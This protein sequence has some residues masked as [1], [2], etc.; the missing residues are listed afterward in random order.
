MKH[1]YTLESITIIFFVVI[2]IGCTTN[3]YMHQL[4]IIDALLIDEQSTDAEKLL[5][6]IDT[7]QLNKEELAFYELLT[8]QKS[9]QLYHPIKKN[10][11]INRCIGYFYQ[12][13]D[14]SKLARAYYYK[15]ELLFYQGKQKESVI[16]YKQ[17]EKIV[18]Q[19]D[20][21]LRHHIYEAVAYANQKD[22]AYALS[23]QYSRA[24]L[25]LSQKLHKPDWEAYAYHMMASNFEG[26][27]RHD[28][29]EIY[30][31][32]VIS[33]LP[34]MTEKG[35]KYILT[36]LGSYYQVKDSK[37][38]DTLMQTA[39]QQPNNGAATLFM[40]GLR[41]NQ[42]RKVEAYDLLNQVE[43][44]EYG[45]NNLSLIQAKRDMKMGDGD[46]R[47]A[48]DLSMQIMALKDSFQQVRARQ[49]L[50]TVQKEFNRRVEQEKIF[51]LISYAIMGI[52]FLSMFI[53]AVVFYYKYRTLH[54]HKLL[55]QD[56]RQ[57]TQLNQQVK[58]A[59]LVP[60]TEEVTQEEKEKRIKMLHHKIINIEERHSGILAIGRL[61]YMDIKEEKTTI[62]WGKMD[63]NAFAE[64][65]KLIDIEFMHHLEE[66]YDSL[67]DKN[68]TLLILESMKLPCERIALI[69]GVSQ[70]AIRTARSRIE[71][72]HKLTPPCE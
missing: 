29:T 48:N 60:D 41:Y 55:D 49:N 58:M 10:S 26:L 32:L 34:K 36:S 23:L 43:A 21:W 67:T 12:Q 19:K 51:R 57:I 50:Q 27:G 45:K 70:G 52:V 42:G 63:F 18:P 33:L 11:T 25:Y 64:Y 71:K 61:R 66:D 37:V 24:S 16:S 15:G 30:T 5:T 3:N 46:Y 59:Q 13:K 62:M 56:R 68:K 22:R 69:M 39:L 7:N 20:W 17:A 65:Y 9:W 4:K 6:T 47:A 40:A 54:L 1:R 28:S 14:F 72:K 31:K 38:L 35:K 53:I 8:I 2:I 44:T